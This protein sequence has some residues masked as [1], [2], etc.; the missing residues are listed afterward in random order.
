MGKPG[1]ESGQERTTGTQEAL[2]NQK[3][4]QARAGAA[5]WLKARGKIEGEVLQGGNAKVPDQ[6]RELVNRYFEELGRKASK[7]GSE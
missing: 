2:Q 4:D 5:D 6:Y 3:I 1:T 7:K